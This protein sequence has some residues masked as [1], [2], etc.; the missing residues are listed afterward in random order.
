MLWSLDWD[1]A[2]PR[3]PLDLPLL[4]DSQMLLIGIVEP[5]VGR[6]LLGRVDLD[7]RTAHCRRRPTAQNDHRKAL[8]T[9]I[10][11]NLLTRAL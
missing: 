11:R 2:S 9:Q 7:R 5:G 3:S 6:R 10:Q 8:Y 1:S 4:D